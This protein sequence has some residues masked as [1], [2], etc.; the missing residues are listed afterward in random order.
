MQAKEDTEQEYREQECREPAC[1]K[2][3]CSGKAWV[4]KCAGNVSDGS[5]SATGIC[6][7]GQGVTKRC[8]LS[9]LT[10]NALVYEPKCG[11]RGGVQLYIHRS[12]NKLWRY[13][14]IFYLWLHRTN[15]QGVKGGQPIAQWLNLQGTNELGPN[16][17]GACAKGSSIP[18]VNE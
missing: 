12:P 6:T 4:S 11:G 17:A 9:W 10:N 15:V 14:F 1:R 8:R 13:N 3:V 5:G 16:V 18:V 7:R 2:Q